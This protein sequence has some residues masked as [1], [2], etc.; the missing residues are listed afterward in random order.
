M[1]ALDPKSLEIIVSESPK[2]SSK[3]NFIE[4]IHREENINFYQA[5]SLLT[6]ISSA[7]SM[8]TSIFKAMDKV[9]LLMYNRHKENK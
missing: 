1:F 9:C 7:P 2:G 8:D 3:I 5:V 4:R 6:T